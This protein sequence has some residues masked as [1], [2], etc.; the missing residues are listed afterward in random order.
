MN[1]DVEYVENYKSI[2]KD[3][4]MNKNEPI[5]E[6]I[7]EPIEET[8]KENFIDEETDKENFIDEET[9]KEN[10]IDEETDKEQFI[11]EETDK[12]NFID[13]T[14]EEP[15]DDTTEEPSDDTTENNTIDTN[16][17]ENYNI[18]SVDIEYTID[19][20]IP[21][22]EKLVDIEK[23]NNKVDN[24][25][26]NF[27][28]E[29]MT[30]YKNE[31]SKIYKKYS[32]MNY[33]IKI[34]PKDKNDLVKIV[35]LKNDKKETVIKELTKPNYLYYNDILN[36]LKTN[37]SNERE[38][39]LFHYKELISNKELSINDK[40][41]FQK[42]KDKF[43]NLLEDYYSYTLYHKKM[44]KISTTNSK[45]NLLL[46]NLN[47]IDTLE[48]SKSTLIGDIYSIDTALINEMNTLNSNKL[49]EYNS[50]IQ[51]L[52]GKKIED[53][54]KDTKL[55]EEIK[56]YLD[57]TMKHNLDS[58]LKNEKNKQDNYINYIINKLPILN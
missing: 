12:E 30:N 15:S 38:K 10:F 47:T 33:K 27:N 56:L 42:E 52:L 8:D 58:K 1:N 34:L 45:S 55:K 43:I 31:Y 41:E 18:E 53:I 54:K 17:N 51:Q 28:S 5:D 44:N 57:T 14:T 32:N 22:D 29:I 6:N 35:V 4:D 9:D 40:E 26:N 50:I 2:D 3:N 46:Q 21:N 39:I 37:I 19:F 36:E 7:D 48:T 11:D 25:I 20:L 49:T 24:Y 23:I 16:N 13:D